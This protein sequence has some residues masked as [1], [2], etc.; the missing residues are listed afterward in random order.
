VSASDDIAAKARELNLGNPHADSP[1]PRQTPPPRNDG[2]WQRFERGWVYWS[3]GT[4]A[5]AVLGA[6]FGKYGVLRWEQG[7]LGFPTTDELPT[8][9]GMGRFNHFEGGSIYWSPS[10][11]AHEVHGAIREKWASLGW[12]SSP[13]GYPTTDETET[14]D[15]V[16]R[17]NHFQGGSVYWSPSTGA[18]EVRG[19]IQERWSELGWENGLGYPVTDEINA[20]GQYGVAYSGFTRGLIAWDPLDPGRSF[21]RRLDHGALL[22]VSPGP[23]WTQAVRPLLAHKRRSGMAAFV[24]ELTAWPVGVS[25]YGQARRIKEVIYEGVRALGVRYVLL[26]GDGSRMPAIYRCTTVPVAHWACRWFT[27][28]DLYYANVFSSHVPQSG[29]V[30]TSVD[31]AL[32]TWDAN[33]DNRFAEH[34][35]ADDTRAF[36]PDRVDGV[37]DVAVGR[38]PVHSPAEV[39]TYV[40][41]VINYETAPPSGRRGL[42]FVLD[43]DYDGLDMTRRAADI[44]NLEARGVPVSWLGED[45]PVGT[46]PPSPLMPAWPWSLSEAAANSQWLF[47]VGHGYPAGWDITDAGVPLNRERVREFRNGRNLPVVFVAG[48]STGQFTNC[49]PTQGSYRGIDGRRHTYV[50]SGGEDDDHR[51]LIEHYIDSDPP[52]TPAETRRGTAASPARIDPVLPGVYDFD[53]GST[54][55]ATDWLLNPDGGAIAY[56]GESTVAPN[57]HGCELGGRMLAAYQGYGT[58]LGDMWLKGMLR[59]WIDFQDSDNRIGAPR[60][61]LSYMH[62]FG[63]PSL[64]L[65]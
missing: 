63:D 3:P 52:A 55:V 18:H 7:L 42:T 43:H 32:A 23:Q 30:V 26:L 38:L 27:H 5:H 53:R 62:L 17:F 16:G 39:S 36:N 6:I 57:D 28:A 61:Y 58:V 12:E 8:P 59:Y 21:S 65:W 19:A 13:L 9:D 46:V 41:K 44:A 35:W 33:G 48:C 4:G 24:H 60:L 54:S 15:T 11:A 10:T 34:H 40:N 50:A 1:Q 29:T 49:P 22:I 47:Y 51:E 2:Y 25:E 56:F 14:P 64:R 31:S 37:A 45:W 20:V